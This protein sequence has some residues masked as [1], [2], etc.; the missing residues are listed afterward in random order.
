MKT[1]SKRYRESLK[2]TSDTIYSDISSAF[3]TLSNFKKVNFDETI[4]ASFSLGVDPKQSSQ[5]VRGTVKLPISEECKSSCVYRESQGSK[6]T[7]SRSRRIGRPYLE[8]E[9][10]VGPF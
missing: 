6:K 10:R 1:R 9:G 2:A 5:A 8:G 3:S 7:R 4:E